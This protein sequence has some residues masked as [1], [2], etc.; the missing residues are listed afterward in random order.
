MDAFHFS[1]LNRA[2]CSDVNHLKPAWCYSTGDNN[3]YLF[4]P[5]SIVALDTSKGKIWTSSLEA[6][7]STMTNTDRS[8]RRIFFASD[9]V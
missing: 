5:H 6:G 4:T 8:D 2:C 1:S 3:M 7:A 9:H